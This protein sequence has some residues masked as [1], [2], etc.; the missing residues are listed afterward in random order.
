MNDWISGGEGFIRKQLVNYLDGSNNRINIFYCVGN[1]NPN[2]SLEELD[3]L[4]FE[5]PKTIARASVD[6]PFRLITFGSVHEDSKIINPYMDSKRKFRDFLVSQDLNFSW[7]HFQ[8]HTLYS[9]KLPKPYMFLGQ[10]LQA[11]TTG[12]KFKMSSG[13]QLR[14]FHH[15]LEVVDA[16][17]SLLPEISVNSV[18]QVSSNNSIRLVDLASTIF[19]H[20]GELKNLEIG[21]LSDNEN[22]IYSGG[23]PVSESLRGLCF[24]DPLIEMPR[25]ISN[26]WL[27][28]Q[29]TE[30]SK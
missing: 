16:I 12:S 11:L 26:V 30:Y 6:L 22:E 23:Y 9:E 7:N 10:I 4:N 17:V 8:L 20:M 29:L 27:P 18:L 13:T 28:T 1:T 3:T 15:T 2:A 14:Q 24:R 5:L 21:T 25:I 19:S